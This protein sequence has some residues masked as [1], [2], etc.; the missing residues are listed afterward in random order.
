MGKKV[1]CLITNMFEDSEYTDPANKFKEAGHEVVAIEKE[2]GKSVQGKQGNDKVQIDKGI[3]EVKAADYDALFIPGGFSPDILRADERFVLFTKEMM[4]AKK[5]V[6]AICH[7]PQLLITA[8]TL[9]GRDATGYKSIH[10]DME[11]AGANLH[12]EEVV[13]CQNQL[14][15]SRTP[16]DLPAFIRESLKLLSS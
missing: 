5:P 13:V 10:V 12:D 1:A 16:D 11:Y 8:K 15:T 4:E 3:D 9:E 7:G 2:S 14:V 6:F